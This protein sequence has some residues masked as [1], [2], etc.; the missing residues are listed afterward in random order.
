MFE[1][2][3]IALGLMMLCALLL[4]ACGK[5]P[6]TD[7]KPLR[8][9]LCALADTVHG[10][11]GIAFVSDNDTVTINNGVKY[12]MMSVFKL[13][14]AIAVADAMERM[15]GS[16]DS[17]MSIRNAELDRNTWSPMLKHVGNADF[18]ISVGELV[19]YALVSSDNNASNL[20][21]EKIISPQETDVFVK[22]VAEDTTF[23]ILYSEAEMMRNHALSYY[24]HTSPLSAG[25]LIKQVFG[26]DVICD[27]SRDAIKCDL[28]VV[29]T[30]QDRLAAVFTN[31]DN[32]VFFAH[33]TG[34]GYR[35]DAGELVAHNDVGYFR[36][37]DGRDYSLAV[38]IRDFTGSEDEASKVI[39]DISRCVYEYFTSR[40]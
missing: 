19:K 7:V 36:F 2:G 18:D 6:A 29:T 31:G 5:E 3:K 8:E 10:T 40:Q 30:G 1:N 34:R 39:A 21:F 16:F 14:Q 11:V 17:V 13:H 15:G 32:D 35:N 37:P 28:S 24:N 38:F 22:S 4:P 33:K 20:L 23:Q 26:S 9:R 27:G 25:L 12:P